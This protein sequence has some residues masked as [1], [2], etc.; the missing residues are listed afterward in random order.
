M[1]AKNL[2]ALLALS[3]FA[4]A[5]SRAE[6]IVLSGGE[7]LPIGYMVPKLPALKGWHMVRLIGYIKFIPD[8]TEENNTPVSLTGRAEPTDYAA[9]DNTDD[10]FRRDSG[11]IRN[12]AVDAII[13]RLPDIADADGQKFLVYSFG[14]TKGWVARAYG[15]EDN[16]LLTFSLNARTKADYDKN[17]PVFADLVKRYAYKMR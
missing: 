15:V 7:S 3:L 13:Q 4:A 16:Y 8:G 2:I 1:H 10:L 6:I 5:P 12:S 14:T 11:D 9:I 17:F